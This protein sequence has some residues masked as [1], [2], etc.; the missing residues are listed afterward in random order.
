MKGFTLIELLLALAIMATILAII[1]GSYASSVAIM[2]DSRERVE[3][4]RE[5]RLILKMISAEIQSA[6]ISPDNEKLKFEGEETELHFSTASGGRP[7]NLR[8]IGIQEIS[9]YLEPAPGGGNFLMR[10]T[11]WPVDDDIR[12]GGETFVL[13]EGLESLTFSYYGAEEGREEWCWEEEE[14]K[15]PTAVRITKTFRD[16]ADRKTSFSTLV[17]IPLG[18]R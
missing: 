3:L 7:F 8:L 13:L 10:R 4:H 15:L 18:K 17:S 12:Q 1:Y 11:Q 16:N 6:F 9:Y 5:A 2:E 14:G